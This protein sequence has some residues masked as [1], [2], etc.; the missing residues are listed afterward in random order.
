MSD[1][2]LP[3]QPSTSLSPPRWTLVGIAL[4]MVATIAIAGFARQTGIGATGIHERVPLIFGS[5]DEVACVAKY[6]DGRNAAAGRWL[7]KTP[8]HVLSMPVIL[9]LFPQ[10]RFIAMTARALHGL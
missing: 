8:M 3:Q 2:A 9:G 10:A 5:L 4:L 6:Y 7:E 1:T